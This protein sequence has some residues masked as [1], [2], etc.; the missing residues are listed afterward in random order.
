MGH[1]HDDSVDRYPRRATER[2]RLQ[3]GSREHEVDLH[4]RGVHEGDDRALGKQLFGD[5]R[6]AMPQSLRLE[7]T[8]EFPK[9]R[10]LYVEGDVDGLRR[11]RRAPHA[12]RLSPEYEPRNTVSVEH[13]SKR[14]QRVSE[15]RHVLH[16][17]GARVHAD[18]RPDRRGES[19]RPASRAW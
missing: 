11:T 8:D 12:H 2:Q 19:L 5:I 10:P 17:R 18:G 3:P 13:P 1:W 4:S 7:L 9:T 14:V 16:D 6:K 15:R